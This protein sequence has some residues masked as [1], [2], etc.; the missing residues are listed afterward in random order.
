MEPYEKYD[1]SI[2]SDITINNKRYAKNLYTRYNEGYITYKLDGKYWSFKFFY[3]MSDKY[4]DEI[5]ITGDGNEIF[6]SGEINYQEN[7]KYANINVKGMKYIKI[8]LS[9]NS[10]IGNLTLTP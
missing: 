8:T 1:I 2:D 7:A 3:G 9:Y 10:A 6:H 4:K 5:S